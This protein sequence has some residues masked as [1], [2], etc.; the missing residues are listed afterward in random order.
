VTGKKGRSGAPGVTR[1]AGPGRNPKTATIRAG[2]PVS[3]TR[4][5]AAGV[6][7]IGTGTATIERVSTERVVRIALEDGS[8]LVLTVF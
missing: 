1:P 3:A 2:N 7:H 4:V 8:T 5:F 6:E